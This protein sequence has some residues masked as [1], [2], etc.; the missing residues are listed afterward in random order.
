MGGS[1][2]ISSIVTADLGFLTS[3]AAKPVAM[4]VACPAMSNGAWPLRTLPTLRGRGR[5]PLAHLNTRLQ[6][7]QHLSFCHYE[8]RMVACRRQLAK[9]VQGAAYCVLTAQAH[10]APCSVVKRLSRP[11]LIERTNP[12]LGTRTGLQLACHSLLSVS[13]EQSRPATQL[14]RWTPV[15][16]GQRAP[17]FRP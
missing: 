15:A 12:R 1:A 10:K 4:R 6:L 3:S 5:T 14:H 2:H 17:L 8:G 13:P 16:S 9:A 11:L 7:L